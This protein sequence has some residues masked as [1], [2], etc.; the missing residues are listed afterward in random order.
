MADKTINRAA[1]AGDCVYLFA[2]KRYWLEKRLGL[3]KRYA[4]K[5]DKRTGKRSIVVQVR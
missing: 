1:A 2:G 3:A 4:T 5:L